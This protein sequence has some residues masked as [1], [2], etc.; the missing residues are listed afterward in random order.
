[1][2]KVKETRVALKGDAALKSA[3][4]MSETLRKAPPHSEE[5]QTVSSDESDSDSSSGHSSGS[6]SDADKR[7]NTKKPKPSKVKETEPN[8]PPVPDDSS[9]E[10][11]DSDSDAAKKAPA[12]VTANGAALKTSKTTKSSKSSEKVSESDDSSEEEESDDSD[13]EMAD[14]DKPA[15]APARAAGQAA[16]PEATKIVPP[17]PFVPPPGYKALNTKTAL[18]KTVTSLF[19]PSTLASKQIWH[20]TAP[21]SVPLSQIK[22]VSLSAIQSHQTILSHNGTDY[23][24]SEEPTNNARVLVPSSKT[25]AYT[26]IEIPVSKSLHLQQT[27]NLPNL[28][29]YQADPTT[30]SNAAANLKT[31]A[32]STPR[33]Q[34]KGMRM[35]YKPPGFGDSDPGVIGSSEDESDANAKQTAKEARSK[36]KRDEEET[37]TST[38]KDKKRRKAEEAAEKLTQ[39]T[40]AEVPETAEEKARKKAEKKDKK[41]KD[42]K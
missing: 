30:G 21:S 18:A 4:K 28:S 5:V 17:Q 20:I 33:P 23:N 32:I 13:V 19:D 9:E 36:R 7:K 35:R 6:E 2:P 26:T 34:P 8:S 12:T 39:G 25:D 31:P 15:A 24:L 42:K 1:M 38:G 16:A 11:E 10:D 40:R 14:A 22:S 27:I 41:K 37:A 3:P 29:A